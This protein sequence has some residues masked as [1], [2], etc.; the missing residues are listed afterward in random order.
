M[1]QETPRMNQGIN[2]VTAGMNKKVQQMIDQG[3]TTMNKRNTSWNYETSSIKQGTIGMYQGTTIMNQGNTWTQSRGPRG[4]NRGTAR[5]NQGWTKGPQGKQ[6]LI[7]SGRWNAV[8]IVQSDYRVLLRQEILDNNLA[9]IC[10]LL[11]K[12]QNKLR[13]YLY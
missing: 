7:G 10:S 12:G 13:N 6:V 1:N 9:S 2:L 5:M 3:I 11:A 8:M 4:M